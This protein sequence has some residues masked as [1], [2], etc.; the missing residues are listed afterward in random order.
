MAVSVAVVGSRGFC[1]YRLLCEKLDELRESVTVKRLVSGG[2]IGAD[3]LAERYAAENDLPILVLKPNWRPKGEYVRSAG[4][5]RNRDIVAQADVVVAFWDNHSPG[6][7]STI[8]IAR[9][10]HKDVRVVSY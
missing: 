3:R 9:D 6:T 10:T 8:Q 4:I 5:Q 7:R 1:N 2:A